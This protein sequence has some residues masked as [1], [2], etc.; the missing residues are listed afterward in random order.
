MNIMNTIKLRQTINQEID[1][2]S[3]EKLNQV[4][5]FIQQV[6]QTPIQSITDPLA[7]FIGQVDHGSLAKNI[8]QDPLVGLFVGSSDL[9]EKSEEILEFVSNSLNVEDDWSD[10]IGSIEAEPDLSSNYKSYLSQEL[11]E[12]YDYH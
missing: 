10:F 4:L 11:G 12:K 5:Q 7:D 6:A 8:D 2:L 9:S 1:Q 3:E